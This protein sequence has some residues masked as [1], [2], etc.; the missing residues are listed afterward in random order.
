MHTATI[1][2][3]EQVTANSNGSSGG[4]ASFDDVISEVT[5][6]NSEVN[7]LT[8]LANQ[9][10]AKE[11]VLPGSVIA[12]AANSTP[13]GYLLCNG[14]AV[15]RTP[16]AALF[17][18]IG[19]TYGTGDGSTTFNLPNLTNAKMVTSSSVSVYGTGIR[20]ALK[21]VSTPSTQVYEMYDSHVLDATK[22]TVRVNQYASGTGLAATGAAYGFSTKSDLTNA[23][24]ANSGLV[25]ELQT[26]QLCYYI[27]Y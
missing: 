17:A 10:L 27:K 24:I 21:D 4:D 2:A 5:F 23:G 12:W 16:Y 25:G 20:F 19:T 22:G 7:R 26:L 15:S 1:E 13:N 3:V 8:G 9:A 6:L 11:S 14:A 18:A